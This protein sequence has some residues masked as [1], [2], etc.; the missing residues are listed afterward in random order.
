MLSA[1]ALKDSEARYRRLFEAAQDQILILDVKTGAITDANP[2]LVELLGYSH[3]EFLGMALWDIGLFKDVEESKK[4]FRELRAKQYIRYDDMPL[5]T[6]GGQCINVEFV[7]NVYTVNS[8]KVIQC[9]IRDISKRKDAERQ[10]ERLRQG[11][12]MEAVG[13]FAGSLVHDFNNLLGVILGY[14][15]V[16]EKQPDLTTASK[17]MVAE[18]HNAGTSAKNLTQ[19]L[20]AFSRRQALQ[21]V[22]PNLMTP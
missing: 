3:A 10:E 14:C 5:K 13:Q 11:Q 12:K 18:I 8:K 16:R 17:A 21:P 7:S 15:E 6:R 9:N 4:A 2:F 20:L 22:F 1:D 19:G